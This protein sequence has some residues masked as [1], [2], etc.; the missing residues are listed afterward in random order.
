MP[1]SRIVNWPP[2]ALPPADVIDAHTAMPRAADLNPAMAPDASSNRVPDFSL[3][4]Y[5][6][7]FGAGALA[8]MSTHAVRHP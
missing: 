5:V 4:D 2:A 8:A 6:K 7:F 1:S 3:S